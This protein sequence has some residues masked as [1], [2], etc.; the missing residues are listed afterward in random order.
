[1]TYFLDSHIVLAAPV[2]FENEIKK[3]PVI[4]LG[5]QAIRYY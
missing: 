2:K 4:H 3:E 1:M 5:L